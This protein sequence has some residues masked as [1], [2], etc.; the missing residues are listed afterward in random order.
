MDKLSFFRQI[1]SGLTN[2][3]SSKRFAA[4]VILLLIVID[5]IVAQFITILATYKLIALSDNLIRL[6]EINKN[7]S[8]DLL[9]AEGVA[10]G[11]IAAPSIVSI[12]RRDA[13]VNDNTTKNEQ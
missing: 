7:I 9:I 1:I 13:A 6:F 8:L 11:I 2:K 12:F 3:A 5:N 10:L 4:L